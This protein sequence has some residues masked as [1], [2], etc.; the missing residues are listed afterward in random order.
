MSVVCALAYPTSCGGCLF[1][2]GYSLSL[3]V[4][5]LFPSR[6]KVFGTNYISGNYDFRD[7]PFL[8]NPGALVIRFWESPGDF[9]AGSR[10]VGF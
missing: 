4:P 9:R 1:C 7:Y 6:K 5:T 8:E 2:I 10:A 3:L